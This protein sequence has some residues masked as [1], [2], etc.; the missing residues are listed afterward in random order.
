MGNSTLSWLRGDVK[1]LYE[2]G[3][4]SQSG[5]RGRQ[6]ASTLRWELT[7][8]GLGPR[9]SNGDR[10]SMRWSIESRVPF[11]T[12]PLAETALSLPEDFL[13]S[14]GGETKHF[15]RR[16]L[17]GIVPASIL[18]RRDKI[19][20]QTPK[21]SWLVG[22]GSEK[23]TSWLGGLDHLEVANADVVKAGI[24]SQLDQGYVT[25]ELWRSRNTALWAE[26]FF[27]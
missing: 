26:N 20:F 5:E 23:I 21:Y 25:P 15:L 18:D 27:G 2:K 14:R 3:F 7:Q 10:N 13:L 12:I 19:G 16:A 6:L 11:L 8:G 1:G 24:R 17:R 22:L 9:I 4:H